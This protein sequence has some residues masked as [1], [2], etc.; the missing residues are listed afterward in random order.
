MTQTASQEP[1]DQCRFLL[2]LYRKAQ[3]LYGKELYDYFLDH[4]V[5]ST[6]SKIGF[7]HFVSSDQKTLRLTTWNEATLKHCN[8]NYTAQYP[9]EQAGNWVDCVRLKKPVIY[10]DYPS[11]PNR[12]GLPQGHVPIKRILSVPIVEEGKVSII[13]GVGNKEDP[14]T[15]RDTVQLEVIA[16]EL[17]RIIKQRQTEIELLESREKYHSLFANM[18][19]AFAYCIMLFNEK[20]KP[21]DFVCLE[22]NKAFEKI[23]NVK[24]EAL[25]GKKATETIPAV[26]DMVQREIE[27]LGKVTLEKTVEKFEYFFKNRKAWFLISVY[28]PKQGYFA[29]VFQD[30]TERKE[31][32]QALLEVGE[33]MQSKLGTLLSPDVEIDET[34]LVNIIDITSLQATIDY[35]S[36]ITE[37]AFALIDLQGNIIVSA[38][39]QDI[40]AKFHRLNPQTY[41]NC[42]ESDVE[43]TK[44]VKKGEIRLYKCKN[45]LWDV[46]TP[47]YIGER[48]VANV[49]FGQFFFDDENPDRELFAAQSQKFGFDKEQY[50]A[51]LERVPRFNRKNIMALMRL[52]VRLTEELS[53]VSRANLKLAKALNIQQQL[54]TQLESKAK[55]VKEYAAQMEQLAE[56]RAK[57]LKDAERLSA[58]GATAGMVGHDI[59]NPLQ[60]IINHLY[61][62]QKR[63]EYCP[64]SEYKTQVKTNMASIEENVRYINKI[65]ADLQD[66]ARPLNPIMEQIDVEEAVTDSLAM[67]TIP[68]N[69]QLV[70][71][72]PQNIPKLSVDYTMLKRVLV[73]L[74]QN[75]VQA[76]PNG[77]HLMISAI[78]EDSRIEISVQDTGLGIPR[79]VQAKI[80]TPLITTK[81]KGQG[82]GLPVV[83]RMTEA[84]GG[85]VT[86]ETEAEVG[87]KFTLKFPA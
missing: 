60:S 74:V 77:G 19:D 17:N 35:L 1:T 79:E 52:Y 71:D 51:S 56:Q 9:M 42:I 6:G 78:V 41:K 16:N 4:A 8:A 38:G 84:M 30:I 65:V 72:I 45:N 59:R 70:F 83:K 10:N 34:E 5:T 49:F 63:I 13:F 40:C 33:Q 27:K 23:M 62:A 25:V 87:T 18:S 37:V 36:A 57:Q 32:E 22:V 53:E 61:L 75:A 80:F 15:E 48:H 12:K 85:T 14:Y 66:F 11:S 82:F 47:L 31:Q 58:I 43:L 54:Q 73:N 81:A 26:F 64:E 7:F 50:L 39:W 69:I 44:G 2:E 21:Y 67:V 55:E 86:F 46:V 3:N 29:A 24:A 68:E 76:M 28:S 20:G